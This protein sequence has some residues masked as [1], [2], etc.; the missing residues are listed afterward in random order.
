MSALSC[1]RWHSHSFSLLAPLFSCKSGSDSALVIR[2]S[3][4]THSL[5]SANMRA[6]MPV[7]IRRT[8][9]N[10]KQNEAYLERSGRIN[11]QREVIQRSIDVTRATGDVTVTAE[12][13]TRLT[14]NSSA[15]L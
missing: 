7:T 12:K 5:S 9:S 10:R 2:A 15:T 3:V 4:I 6:R 11:K 14:D 1:V 13:L 8:R